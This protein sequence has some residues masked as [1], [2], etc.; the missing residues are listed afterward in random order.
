MKFV[1][2]MLQ[3]AALLT[4][5]GL[6]LPATVRAQ[7]QDS[8]SLGDI[9]RK[10]REKKGQEEDKGKKVFTNENLPQTG[11]ISTAGAAPAASASGAASSGTGPAKGEAEA[12]GKEGQEAAGAAGADAS[13]SSQQKLDEARKALEDAKQNEGATE[14]GITRLEEKMANETDDSRRELYSNAIQ[15]GQVNLE[16]FKKERA[17][18]EKKLAEME[19]AAKQNQ[20]PPQEAPPQ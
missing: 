8:Q 14:R 3:A 9:A 12:Q 1:V 10:Q 15:H 6:L 19:A 5:S 7:S 17:E 18:A 4:L 20:P 11:G 16:K 13:M 2:K